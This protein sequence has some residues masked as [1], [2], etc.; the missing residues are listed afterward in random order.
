MKEFKN[1]KKISVLSNQEAIDKYA[2]QYKKSH[3][4]F[5]KNKKSRKSKKKP[6]Y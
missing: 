1:K 3:D 4:T 5:A 6:K 2:A